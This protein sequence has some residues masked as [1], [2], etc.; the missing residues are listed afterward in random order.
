MC[1]GCSY[2]GAA[3]GND[4]P[5]S[6][7][8]VVVGNVVLTATP[9]QGVAPL[10]TTFAWTGLTPRAEPYTCVID[11]GDGSTPATI[12]D[13][14]TTTSQAHTYTVTSA[15]TNSDGAFRATLSV[16]GTKKVAAARVSVD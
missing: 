10:A 6:T 1:L 8:H 15:L 5:D 13:C 12:A 16:V 3:F 14:A 7:V 4:M 11:F 9:G 2:G